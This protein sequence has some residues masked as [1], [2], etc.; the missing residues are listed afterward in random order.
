MP[1]RAKSL[2]LEYDAWERNTDTKDYQWQLRLLQSLWRIENNLPAKEDGTKC[3]GAELPICEAKHSLANYLT[4]KIRQVVKEEVL[5]PAKSQGK[6]YGKPRIFN[7]L[8]S[9][10]PLCFNLFGELRK[11]FELASRLFAKMTQ[12]RFANVTGIEFEWSPG[13]G[14]DKLTGDKSA[15]DVYVEF[16]SANSRRGFLGIEVKYHENLKSSKNYH[17]PRYDK[18]ATDMQCFRPDALPRLRKAGPLQQMWR[19][20]LLVGVHAHEGAFDDAAFVF[21]YP[22]V[23]TDCCKAVEA[24]QAGL[25]DRRTFLPWTLDAIV[26][27]LMSLTDKEWV[28]QFHF[29]YLDLDRLRKMG[30]NINKKS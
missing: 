1:S 7:H 22:E 25:T 12:G 18:V 19:D 30:I 4:P 24:Y 23:N 5:D 13:R 29:R 8:L 15:F 26:A 28:R 9:S 2:L 21:L 10:Q 27:C 3:Y 20:H 14:D 17:R 11:D 6:L 16:R